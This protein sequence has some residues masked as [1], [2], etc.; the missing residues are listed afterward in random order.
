MRT[1]KIERSKLPSATLLFAI[2]EGDI[3]FDDT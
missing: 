2:I 1:A 3:I